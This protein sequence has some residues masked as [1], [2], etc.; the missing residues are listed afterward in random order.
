[1]KNLNILILF[2]SLTILS[3]GNKK[4]K[5]NVDSE[6]NIEEVS[7][8]LKQEIESIEALNEELKNTEKSIEA[9]I[10]KLDDMLNEI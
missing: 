9:S 2:L 7:T 10:K 3:C 1:M 6:A 4:E 5:K 8:E